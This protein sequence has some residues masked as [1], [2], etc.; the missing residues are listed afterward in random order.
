MSSLCSKLVAHIAHP[1]E[2]GFCPQ[3][4]RRMPSAGESVVGLRPIAWV[5]GVE[6]RSERIVRLAGA[7]EALEGEITPCRPEFVSLRA[8]FYKVLI[9]QLHARI[10]QLRP[11]HGPRVRVFGLFSSFCPVWVTG[12]NLLGGPR[13]SGARDLLPVAVF[14]K[15]ETTPLGAPRGQR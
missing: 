8:F 12:R 4:G 3:R 9:L 7:P 6:G 2:G 10:V 13:P 11:L 1:A 5:L 14:A 15:R